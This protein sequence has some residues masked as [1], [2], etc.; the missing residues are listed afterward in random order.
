MV[1]RPDHP[2]ASNGAVPLEALKAE[3]WIDTGSDGDA[4][5]RALGAQHGFTPDFRHRAEGAAQLRRL[6]L[7]GLGSALA[8]P[9]RDRDRLAVLALAEVDVTRPVVLAA[10]AGRRRSLAADS[11]VRAAR[12][13]NW[14]AEAT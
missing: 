7:A 3:P 11:L 2:L 8:P 6:I 12:A 14:S 5:L 13:R 9:P 4:R 1:T 10:I